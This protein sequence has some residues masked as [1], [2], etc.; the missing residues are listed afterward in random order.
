MD[1][2]LLIEK[3]WDIDENYVDEHTLVSIMSRLR[4]K[5]EIGDVKYIKTI[6]GI[7]YQWLSE[8]YE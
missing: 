7:G 8:R 3:I 4:K 1:L 2:R 5:I 6:Y